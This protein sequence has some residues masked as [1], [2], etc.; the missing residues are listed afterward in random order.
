M[1]DSRDGV[2]GGAIGGMFSGC[3]CLKRQWTVGSLDGQ[4]DGQKKV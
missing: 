3:V 2:I 4:Q 1:G